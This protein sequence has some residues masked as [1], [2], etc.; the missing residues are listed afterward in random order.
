MS[1]KGVE[2]EILEAAGVTDNLARLSIGLED[3]EDL[4]EDLDQALWKSG[5]R[6]TSASPDSPITQ[7][8][9]R[10]DKIKIVTS[11]STQTGVD[12]PKFFRRFH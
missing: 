10:S 5:A 1:H 12:T 6:T 7:N 8:G 4:L 11:Q 9:H 2:P 3:I